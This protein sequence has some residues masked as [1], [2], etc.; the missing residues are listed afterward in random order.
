MG[1]IKKRAEIKARDGYFFEE[2]GRKGGFNFSSA[3][4]VAM[5]GECGM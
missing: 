2:K 1:E 4:R 5:K 3:C